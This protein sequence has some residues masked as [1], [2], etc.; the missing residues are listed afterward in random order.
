MNRVIHLAQR[1]K[2]RNAGM[3]P[4]DLANILSKA[5]NY[6]EPELEVRILSFLL[7]NSFAIVDGEGRPAQ[8]AAVL[9]EARH[10]VHERREI[11]PGVLRLQFPEGV[12]YDVSST[13]LL[14]P[15]FA[16]EILIGLD[17]EYRVNSR[18]LRN[19]RLQMQLSLCPE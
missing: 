16:G 10:A 19:A 7:N 18:T 6:L 11:R 3:P 9:E 12:T 17:L 5:I 15:E 4:Q 13:L 1:K 2:P 8:A 14:D